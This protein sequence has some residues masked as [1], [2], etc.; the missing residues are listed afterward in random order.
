MR[1]PGRP[2]A[3]QLNISSENII[4]KAI[5]ILNEK[6]IEQLSMRLIAKE[7][8]ITPMALYHYFADKNALIKAIG[9]TL[10]HSINATDVIGACSKIEILLLRYREKVIQYPQITLAIFNTSV[11]F[12]EQ[13]IRITK[14]LIQLLTEVG[15]STKQAT[16]W[17]HIL[18]DYTHGEAL[19]TST[20]LHN[21]HQVDEKIR[22]AQENYTEALKTLLEISIGQDPI[23]SG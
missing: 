17:G 16:Q 7:M 9:N 3:Q 22:Y 23:G 10:Y 12:P 5:E 15:L 20:L 18:I 13:A 21:E 6:G 8:V 1:K 2:K 4:A 11:L 14:E 19:A